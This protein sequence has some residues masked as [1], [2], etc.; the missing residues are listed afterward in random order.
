MRAHDEAETM[1][2]SGTLTRLFQWVGKHPGYFVLGTL[3][4]VFLSMRPAAQTQ[5]DVQ[6][7]P[8]DDVPL[9]V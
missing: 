4:V 6:E 1:N 2:G 3:M 7:S 9:F 8:A 5:N